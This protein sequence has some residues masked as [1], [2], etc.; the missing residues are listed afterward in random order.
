MLRQEL[1]ESLTNPADSIYISDR[2]QLE[3]VS[4]QNHDDNHV[5]FSYV[6]NN[7]DKIE[8]KIEKRDF[9]PTEHVLDICD[10]IYKHIRGQKEAEYLEVKNIIDGKYSYGIDGTLPKTEISI[11]TIKWNGHALNI[12]KSAYSNLFQPHIRLDNIGVEAYLTK[13]NK[14]LYIYINGS[15]GAGAYAAK[16]IFDEKKYITRIIGTNE[17]TVGFDFLDGIAKVED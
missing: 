3:S 15:D 2:N 6:S 14:N 5:T 8:I 11:M 16:L 9:D 10:T 7:K 17:M 1:N 4:I 13:D 12:P